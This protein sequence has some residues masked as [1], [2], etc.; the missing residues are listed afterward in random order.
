[1]IRGRS[2]FDRLWKKEFSF[3]SRNWVGDPIDVNNA[4]FPS[5]TNSLGRF[6]P[7]GLF[8]FLYFGY[9]IDLFLV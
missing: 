8:F 5:F 1:M 9:F 7:E 6:R 2:S 3:I 4:P